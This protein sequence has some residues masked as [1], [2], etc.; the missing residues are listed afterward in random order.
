MIDEL[1]PIFA[2]L[3][4]GAM[5]ME[6]IRM[7]SSRLAVKDIAFEQRLTS[8]PAPVAAPNGDRRGG[9]QQGQGGGEHERPVNGARARPKPLSGRED[10][11]RAFLALCIASPDDGAQMLASV[12]ID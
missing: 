11:E 4:E 1:R 12:D 8:A 9:A 2:Q 10:A 3:G 7:A 5:R 6:L